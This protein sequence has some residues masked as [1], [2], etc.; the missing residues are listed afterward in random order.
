[1]GIATGDAIVSTTFDVPA[2]I[3]TGPS[4][5][6]VVANGIASAAKNVTIE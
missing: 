1:M 2:K 6:V 4:Q 5:L 3:E